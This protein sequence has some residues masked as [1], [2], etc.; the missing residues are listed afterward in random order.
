MKFA[1]E[2]STEVAKA[3][4]EGAPVKGSWTLDIRES[5]VGVSVWSFYDRA[6]LVEVVK[7]RLDGTPV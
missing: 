4:L 2:G 6:V 7:A 5:D 3:R 1:F